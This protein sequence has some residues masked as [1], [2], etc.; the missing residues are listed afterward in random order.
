MSPRIYQPI[1]LEVN[2]LVSLD[3]QTSHHL[4]HVLRISPQDEF[5]LFNGEGGEFKALIEVIEKKNKHVQVKAKIIEFISREVESPIHIHLAQGVA[6]G[7][8]MDWI[9][10]KAVELGVKEITPLLTEYC[11][12]R[13][14][15]E[16]ETKR[17]EHWRAV[18][19]SACEQSGRN[20][21]PTIYPPCDFHAWLNSKNTLAYD[22]HF[23]LSPHVIQTFNGFN[24]PHG[25]KILVVI[26]PE[27]GF[28]EAEIKAAHQ[29]SFQPIHLGPRVLRTETASIAVLSVLQAQFGD[30]I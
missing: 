17:L 26:G 13:L 23:I 4:V 16:R 1:L 25:T 20:R 2:D 21:I 7:E 24:C 10:Q 9:V 11:N 30:L 22:Y 8:K 29:L 3:T 28:S 14:S 12:V 6:R 5:I 18:M 27:G 19:V 15:H